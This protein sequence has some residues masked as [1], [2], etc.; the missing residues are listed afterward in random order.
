MNNLNQKKEENIIKLVETKSNANGYLRC[1]CSTLQKEGQK[2]NWLGWERIETP[3]VLDLLGNVVKIGILNM[4][5]GG[6]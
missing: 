3:N 5:V 2:C 6:W 1:P 4:I